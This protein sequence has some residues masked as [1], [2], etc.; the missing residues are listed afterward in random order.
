[1]ILTQASRPPSA[2]GSAETLPGTAVGTPAYMSPEQAAGDRERVGPRSDAYS[3]GA[4]LYCLLTGAT[5][6]QGDD[7]G[8]ILASVQMLFSF[9]FNL[10]ETQRKV[11][12]RKTEA[13]ASYKE[14]TALRNS[15]A[16]KHPTVADYQANGAMG[17]GIL[18]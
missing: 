14:A 4:T 3:L 13:M 2:S 10:G 6:F 12:R 15:L 16:R 5:P 18:G 11:D 9:L 1:V 17:Y 7:V 8:A